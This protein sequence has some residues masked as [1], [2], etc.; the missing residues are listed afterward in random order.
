MLVVGVRVVSCEGDV[1]VEGALQDHPS[2]PQAQEVVARPALPSVKP[3]LPHPI[4]LLSTVFIVAC[5]FA[6]QHRVPRMPPPHA[7]P[8]LL[9]PP[10]YPEGRSEPQ[11][12]TG[13]EEGERNEEG[14]P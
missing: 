10:A 14:D 4:Y 6:I 8:S 7:F 12:L 2:R 11:E 3:P 9:K 13:R 5:V 1:S